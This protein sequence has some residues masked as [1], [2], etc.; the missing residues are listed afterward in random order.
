MTTLASVQRTDARAQG[1]QLDHHRAVQGRDSD[2]DERC[3]Q[4]PQ[5]CVC[6]DLEEGRRSLTDDLRVLECQPYHN[7]D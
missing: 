6:A 3:G 4:I 5:R 1:R 7:S 2:A